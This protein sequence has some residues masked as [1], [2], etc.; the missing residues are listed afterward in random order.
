M[1][2][3]RER[4]Y[5]AVYLPIGIV[6]AIVADVAVFAAI[7]WPMPVVQPGG[8]CQGC[9]PPI[10]P[11]LALGQPGEQSSGP[12]H[13]YN[14]TVESAGGGITLGNIIFHVV[15]ATGAIVPPGASWT[16]V[17]INLTGSLAG[18][19]SFGTSTWTFGMDQIVTNDQ[20][21]VLDS[22]TVNLSEQGDVLNVIGSGG[23]FQGSISVSIP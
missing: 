14:F 20:T 2:T 12:N 8:P 3:P 22:G 10:G 23:S 18:S 9:S 17:V 13:W 16:L 21:V 1:P 5:L 7:G 4:H 15:T 6:L 11:S 19:Y